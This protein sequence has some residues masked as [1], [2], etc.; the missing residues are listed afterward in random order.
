V[1]HIL[2]HCN[3]EPALATR[4]GKTDVSNIDNKMKG[5]QLWK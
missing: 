3:H 1:M 2:H 5:R 4:L